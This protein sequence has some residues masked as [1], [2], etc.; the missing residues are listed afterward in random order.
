M[1]L[2]LYLDCLSRVGTGSEVLS[3]T[4]TDDSSLGRDPEGS[5][6]RTG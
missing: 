6:R 2:Y 1:S 4:E 3:S 5:E